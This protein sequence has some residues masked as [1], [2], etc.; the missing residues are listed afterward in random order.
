[1]TSQKGNELHAAEHLYRMQQ[2]QYTHFVV[3]QRFTSQYA[4]SHHDDG[5][6]KLFGTKPVSWPS[7]FNVQFY[8]GWSAARSCQH[9]VTHVAD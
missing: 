1:M 2:A 4:S 7:V 6:Q 3:R 9:P 5:T 8:T